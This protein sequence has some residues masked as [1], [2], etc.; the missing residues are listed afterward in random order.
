MTTRRRRRGFNAAQVVVFGF[1]GGNVIGTLLLL[2]PVSSAK[3]GTT[4]LLT[5]SFTSVSALSLTGLT[6]V[7]TATHW[8]TFGQV[9]ILVLIKVG[10]F[11]IMALG[12][13]LGLVLTQRVS[14][15]TKLSSG[16]EQQALG[17]DDFSHVLTLLFYT[18]AA[19]ELSLTAVL[20]STFMWGYGESFPE[21][22]WHGFFHSISAFNNAGFSTF[23]G[24]LTRFATDPVVLLP[25]ASA[26]IL[27]GL[28]FPVLIEITRRALRRLRIV[29]RRT[30]GLAPRLSLT[31]K[32]V[33]IFSAVLLAGGA[34]YIGFA[35]WQN[36]NTIGD[37][38]VGSKILNSFFASTMARNNG[39]NAVDY[40]HMTRETLVGTDV[41]MFIGG[42]SAGTSGG[43]RITT[44][45]VLIFIV[46]AEIRGDNRVNTGSRRLG[47]SVQRTAVVLTVMS[48]AGVVAA[49]IF[50]QVIT[51]YSTDQ[52]VFE[53][54][55]AFGTCGLS[56]GITPTL[57]VAAKIMLMVMM[58][59][60]RIG[61][62]LV[63]TA[64]ARRARPMTYTLP[65]ERPLI[66]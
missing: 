41:L 54:I 52:I 57:P 6:V 62:V 32:I 12:S 37:M 49:V 8:S 9:I 2:L 66:G 48:L 64:L 30:V 47:V 29:T 28:G 44:F 34:L 40:A 27:G 21:A 24:S 43:L 26:A 65:K 18:S 14:L 38:T 59:T 16:A 46:I 63:A 25:I 61:L 13:L 3:P 23:P 10:G 58:F 1:L 22:L 20:T 51:G 11:G 15:K 55:S 17:L 5:A 56:T 53:V 19:I 60:G 45:A 42:G 7:D 31:T 39:F 33:L 35:E 4:D 36:P 50:M